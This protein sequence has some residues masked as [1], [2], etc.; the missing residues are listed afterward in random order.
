MKH[1][2]CVV[3]GS[4]WCGGRE[5]RCT[6]IGK[7]TI[8][9]ICLDELE[10]VIHFPDPAV[11]NETKTLTQSAAQAEGWFHGPPYAVA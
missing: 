1:S 10:V 3:G 2:D 7:R 8:I 5:W 4:F 9:A 11:P 6:D